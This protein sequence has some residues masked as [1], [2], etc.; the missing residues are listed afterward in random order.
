[1]SR[2]LSEELTPSQPVAPEW[3][4]RE[5]SKARRLYKSRRNARRVNRW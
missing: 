2:R 1:M 3:A 4:K 5:A